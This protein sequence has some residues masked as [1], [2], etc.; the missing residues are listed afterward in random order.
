MKINK[1]ILIL[2]LFVLSGAFFRAEANRYYFRSMSGS[3][4]YLA[5]LEGIDHS[6]AEI[7]TALS[8]K[9]G[10][11]FGP[12][13]IVYGDRVAGNDEYVLKDIHSKG[14]DSVLLY[15]NM[16]FNGL[17][18]DG[19]IA[20]KKMLE[21]VNGMLVGLKKEDATIQNEIKKLNEIKS[22]LV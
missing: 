12:K 10:V 20:Q 3:Q 16:V 18:S 11:P 15:K 21:S 9:Y 13:S 8:M 17:P 22:K 2:S 6:V 4:S 19:Q 1:S 14:G 7:K 5:D